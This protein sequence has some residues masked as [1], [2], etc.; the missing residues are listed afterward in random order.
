MG[1]FP[2]SERDEPVGH[3]SIP[4]SRLPWDH[5]VRLYRPGPDELK[6]L[7]KKCIW[8]RIECNAWRWHFGPHCGLDPMA[9][10][11]RCKRGEP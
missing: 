8:M 4:V 6:A 1:N 2:M 3:T 7:R 11:T 10:L 5:P 9:H